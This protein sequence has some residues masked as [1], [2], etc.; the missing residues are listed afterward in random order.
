M[1][2][3][4]VRDIYAT[5]LPS[6]D[7]RTTTKRS[8]DRSSQAGVTLIELMIV[9]MIVAVLAAIAVPGYR[10]YVL[11]SHRTEARASL[12]ALATAQEKFYLQCNTYT[13]ALD[14]A[15]AT[16]CGTDNIRFNTTSETGL[17]TIAVTAADADAWSATAIPVATE[18]QS[19]DARCQFLSL[20]SQGVKAGSPNS[21]G[22][23]VTAA[24][25]RECWGK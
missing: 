15:A 24:T 16:D 14:P 5:K 1:M 22:S 2:V 9:V 4:Q 12:L 8:C 18:G 3:V 25:T 23:G 7:G 19:Q 10:Q 11:R 17:Y 21:D 13:A 20:N 6:P